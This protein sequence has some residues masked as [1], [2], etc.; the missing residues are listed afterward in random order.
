[1]KKITILYKDGK[2]ETHSL[3]FLNIENGTLLLK[4]NNKKV[5]YLNEMF[6]P[7][8]DA[9]KIKEIRIK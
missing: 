1:M 3:K 9:K 4:T 2:E 6:L 7:E 8:K 5:G